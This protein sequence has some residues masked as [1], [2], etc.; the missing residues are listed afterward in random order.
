LS[1]VLSLEVV[2]EGRPISCF[3]LCRDA[4]I[5]R[6]TPT[7]LPCASLWIHQFSFLHF[8]VCTA[9]DDKD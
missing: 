7:P 5:Y 8:T 1:S 9:C 3:R 4:E 2:T 6:N